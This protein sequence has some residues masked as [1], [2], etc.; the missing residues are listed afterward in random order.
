MSLKIRSRKRRLSEYASRAAQPGQSPGTAI[1]A[2]Q[3]AAATKIDIVTYNEHVLHIERDVSFEMLPAVGTDKV[4][5]V[6]VAGLGSPDIIQAIGKKFGLHKLL[7][8]DLFATEGRPKTESY[9]DI[10]FIQLRLPPLERGGAMDLLSIIAG[11][12]FLISIDEH[13][14]DCFDPVRARLE[15]AGPIRGHGSDYLLYALIDATVDAYFPCLEGEGRILDTLEDSIRDP[16][17]APPLNAVHSIKRRLLGLRRALWPLREVVS[18]LTREGQTLIG[19]QTRIYLRDTYDHVVELIDLV[20][21]YRETANG[22]AE[23]SL[24]MVSARTN[25]VMRFLTIISTIFMPLTF[26]AGVYGMN[27][28]TRSKFNMPELTWRYG[29]IAALGVMIIITIGF[30]IFFKRNGLLQRPGENFEDD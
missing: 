23:L 29:Y 25:D 13:P 10:L 17:R 12:H 24:S 6:H 26:I 11:P 18:S 4:L 8:E 21:L 5:W 19:D 20:E 30:V 14:G 22:M 7:I 9:G 28:D 15:K 27:F 1:T 2:P 3:D 16:R